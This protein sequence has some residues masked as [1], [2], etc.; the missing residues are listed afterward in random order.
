[1]KFFKAKL[2]AVSPFLG[3][4]QEAF[5]RTNKASLYMVSISKDVAKYLKYIAQR[6]L[7]KNKSLH[8]LI[9]ACNC[10]FS[11]IPKL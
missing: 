11:H 10:F 4:I 1:M 5:K 7:N 9:K 2:N 3:L 8:K 6:I